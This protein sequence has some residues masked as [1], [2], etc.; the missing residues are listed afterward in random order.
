MQTI[1]IS[2]ARRQF[3]SLVDAAAGGEEIVIVKAGI[4]IARLVP[5]GRPKI[6]R[7]FGGLKGRCRIAEDFD[8]PLPDD[9]IAA[10]GEH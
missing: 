1:D 9:V 4:P 5:I 3:S 10:F 2:D 8:A 6:A 7:K